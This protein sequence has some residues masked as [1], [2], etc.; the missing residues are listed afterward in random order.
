MSVNRLLLLELNEVN[1]E[2]A[3]GYVSSRPGRYPAI[4]KL[5]QGAQIKTRAE[6][7]YEELEPWIQWVSVHT[8]LSYA[9]HKVYR[10]GD[11][12]DCAEKQIFEE[13]E[14]Q[15]FRVGSVSAMNAA[16]RLRDPAYFI[17]DPWTNTAADTSWW[18]RKLHTAIAQAVNDNAQENITPQNLFTVFFAVLRFARPKHYRHYLRLALRAKGASW[19][20]ALFLDLLLCDVHAAKYLRFSPNFSCLFLNAGAHIQHHYFFNAKPLANQVT[21]NNPHWYVDADKDP[22]E[23]MLGVYDVILQDV[24]ATKGTE[25]VVATGLSQRPY[26]RIKFYYRLRNHAS[27]L[28]LLGINFSNVE[29]RMTRD[30][31]ITFDNSEDASFADH[32][33]KEVLVENSNDVLFKDID[34]RGDNLFVTLTY[35]HEITQDT[36]ILFRGKRMSVYSHVV[37]VAIKNGMHQSEGF[38]FF[39]PDIAPFAPVNGS[40]VKE[41]HETILSYFRAKQSAVD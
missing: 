13:L 5:L 31:L 39:T 9:E 23:E 1:F 28:K 29:P 3:E 30:F 14:E 20:K 25:V 33:L 27:F 15:G 17:P 4:E 7:T 6:T 12:N 19:R 38:A 11:I 21:L 37:F 16:N 26:D 35:P 22:F 2:I 40:H 32:V 36:Y 18:S 34:N 8:G 10:L 41:L 24:L